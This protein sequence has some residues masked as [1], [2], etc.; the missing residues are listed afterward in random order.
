MKLIISI[1][2][3]DKSLK[4][5]KNIYDEIMIVNERFINNTIK[6]NKLKFFS[7]A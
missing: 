4:I 2:K 5:D 6:E 3:V 1:L 7:V